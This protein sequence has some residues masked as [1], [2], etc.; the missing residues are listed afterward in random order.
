[1][2][3]ARE[4]NPPLRDAIDFYNHSKPLGW[5]NRLVAG[6]SLLVMNSLL[7]KEGMAGKVQMIYID[8]PYGIR[9]G[10]NFQPFV[11]RRDVKDGKDDDLTQEPETLK[12][13]RDTWELGIHSYLT[14]L[15]DRLL[16]AR[17][18]L[19]ESG[20]VF[21]QIGDEN[22]HHSRELLDEIF[23]ANNFG[24]LITFQT[25]IPLR[26]KYLPGVADYILWYGK[27]FADGQTKYRK[28]FEEQSAADSAQFSLVELPDGTSRSLQPTERS[29]PSVLP[30]GARIFTSLDLASSGRT[31]SCV[32]DYSWNGRPYSPTAGKSWK[33]NPPGMKKLS[34][35]GRLYATKNS[36]R[37]KLFLADYPVKELPNI[38]ADNVGV[39][40]KVYVVQTDVKAV[41]RC[42]LMTTDPGDLVFDPTCG[43]GTTAYVAEQWG[44]RW[45]TC[46]TSRVAVTLAEQRL[47]T[48]LFDYYTLAKPNEGV[49]GGFV[50]KTVPH[51]TLGSIANNPDIHEGMTRAEID[52]AIS[53]Y[54]DQET[55]YDQ[56]KLDRSKARVTG[57]F[58]LEAVPAVTGGVPDVVPIG[59]SGPVEPLPSSP[60]ATG[61]V[62]PDASVAR[63]GETLRQ[64]EWRD[65]LVSQLIQLTE[66]FLASDK[67]Q[68]RP[69][70]YAEIPTKRRLMLMLNMNRIISHFWNAIRQK[71]TAQ[72]QPVF[73]A[74]HPVRGTADMSPWYTARPCQ[75][76]FHSHVSPATFDSTWEASESFTLERSDLV[77]AWVKNDHLGFDIWY[78]FRGARRRYRPD[79]LVRLV[80]GVTLILETKGKVDEE[81]EAKHEYLAEWVDAVNAH[82][83]FGFWAWAVSTTPDDVEDILAEHANAGSS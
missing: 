36:L 43:S 25:K 5:K 11:N 4:E 49:G 32:F 30:A 38:W 7:E 34:H 64:S 1:M 66:Q 27:R 58:T 13:F 39:A 45:I 80:N 9:Y 29:N 51:V 60:T 67:I 16:L 62:L 55:L 71:N 12:A 53:K 72:R 28:L 41:T 6:D 14:Y 75:P 78:V 17:E 22:L 3:E 46:D 63:S 37:Y 10:S 47:M 23:G 82:G 33:T 52:A 70:A 44:R 61:H 24:G 40:G 69:Q 2:F 19:T 59:A 83:G 31:E 50:Y 48:S 79:F 42:M 35:A 77:Q 8:P 68:M 21:V 26:A 74:E 76:T 54:A 56:P 73:D 20:S 65:E 18:L 81:A 57:P 15:R